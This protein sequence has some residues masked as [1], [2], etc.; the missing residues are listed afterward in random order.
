M[1]GKVS[2]VMNKIMLGVA[3]ATSVPPTPRVMAQETS[4][5]QTQ[6]TQFM[7]Y[8]ELISRAVNAEKVDSKK[9]R[10]AIDQVAKES[11]TGTSINYETGKIE[12]T[13][14]NVYRL[15]EKGYKLG[16][17]DEIKGE[18]LLGRLK[19]YPEDKKSQLEGEMHK[20]LTKGP[21]KIRLAAIEGANYMDTNQI[22]VDVLQLMFDKDTVIANSA[23]Q[24]SLELKSTPNILL[25]VLELRGK[26]EER[27]KLY[28]IAIIY[29][30]KNNDQIMGGKIVEGL[31]NEKKE[32]VLTSVVKLIEE[33][34]MI[35]MQELRNM[36]ISRVND[37]PELMG[38][39]YINSLFRSYNEGKPMNISGDLGLLTE[40][41]KKAGNK[42]KGEINRMT[43][44]WYAVDALSKQ[45][46]DSLATA[47]D[48]MVSRI[49]N[50]DSPEAR[51][52]GVEGLAYICIAWSDTNKYNYLNILRSMVTNKNKDKDEVAEVRAA[53]AVG[54]GRNGY[55]D[56]LNDLATT[57]GNT[58]EDRVVREGCARGIYELFLKNPGPFNVGGI[59]ENAKNE[60]RSI[61]EGKG[62][63]VVLNYLLTILANMRHSTPENKGLL[64]KTNDGEIV[65][66]DVVE[67]PTNSEVP[68]SFWGVTESDVTKSDKKEMQDGYEGW[69]KYMG[70]MARENL[71]TEED[72]KKVMGGLDKIYTYAKEKKGEEK[73]K[74]YEAL[75]G[76]YSAMSTNY[77]KNEGADKVA[78]YSAMSTNYQK[79]EGADK[80]AQMLEEMVNEENWPAVEKLLR[81]LREDLVVTSDK[82]QMYGVAQNQ[83]IINI[84]SKIV[85]MPVPPSVKGEAIKI[86]LKYKAPIRISLNIEPEWP[87]EQRYVVL[88]SPNV[89]WKGVEPLLA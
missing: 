86:L 3:L 63:G 25:T 54:L 76:A 2:R 16:A 23:M 81:I 82:K 6:E 39:L 13:A 29:Y 75:V 4:E 17:D 68:D 43:G 58:N 20:V 32:D 69:A 85:E 50:E 30:L 77:Q 19:T 53:A 73:A 27:I 15:C 79:N 26:S 18:F 10:E 21:N 12:V 74:L 1:G 72:A 36:A 38:S 61:N 67:K 71:L 64:V 83:S 60:V 7:K 5:N 34:D 24:K 28:N 57:M 46:E 40:K 88:V 78:P 56:A 47:A 59:E 11:R 42:A 31:E 33:T 37:Y 52:G 70:N 80:V 9:L 41:Y 55:G 84:A 66:I 49:D 45:D 44:A 14:N 89:F 51:A 87:W 35:Y 62:S 22:A 8:V 48:T 65:K